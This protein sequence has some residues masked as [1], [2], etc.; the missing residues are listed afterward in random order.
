MNKRPLSP[1]LSI[2]KKQITSGV[3]I[4]GRLVPIK[5]HSLFVKAVKMV[6]EKTSQKIKIMIVIK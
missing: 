3:S 6:K 1:H 4:I 5:N 2:Y